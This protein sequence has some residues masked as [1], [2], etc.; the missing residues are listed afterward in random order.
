MAGGNL[1]GSG[2]SHAHFGISRDT[3]QKTSEDLKSDPR[4]RKT[5]ELSVKKLDAFSKFLAGPAVSAAKDMSDALEANPDRYQDFTKF[6]QM[7]DY[8]TL[9]DKVRGTRFSNVLINEPGKAPQHLLLRNDA[10]GSHPDSPPALLVSLDGKSFTPLIQDNGKIVLPPSPNKDHIQLKGS[11]SAS[12]AA[13]PPPTP[14]SSGIKTTS[15]GKSQPSVQ[16]AL[17]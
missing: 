1:I 17:K 12:R 7:P 4:S 5:A 6:E 11:R 8:K 10:F 13:E 3:L 15:A 14:L 9:S 16:P 2:S